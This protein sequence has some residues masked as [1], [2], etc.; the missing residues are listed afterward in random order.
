MAPSSV[1]YTDREIFQR[2]GWR[3]HLCGKRI[4]EDLPRT[5]PDGA[6][7]DHLVPLS[8]GGVDEPHN[9]AAAHW[10]CNQAK[11]VRPANEQ[12]RMPD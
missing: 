11:G 4:R 10:R 6:T 2:D 5:H 7:I 12:L 1:P 3:C 9:L 8:L